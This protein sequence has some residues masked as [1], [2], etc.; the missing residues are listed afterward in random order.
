MHI[1]LGLAGLGGGAAVVGARVGVL[2]LAR[3]RLIVLVDPAAAADPV[4]GP[5]SALCFGG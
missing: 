4:L 5:V 1:P 2:G 3:A